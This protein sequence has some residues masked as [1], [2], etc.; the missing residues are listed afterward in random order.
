MLHKIVSF[1]EQDYK[2]FLELVKRFNWKEENQPESKKED[3]TIPDAHKSIVR[4]R[5]QEAK[6]NPNTMLD[7]DKIKNTF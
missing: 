6:E 4:E 1:P 5:I 7:W 2:L 3:I